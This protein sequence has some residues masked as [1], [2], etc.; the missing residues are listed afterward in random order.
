MADASPLQAPTLRS[1]AL[2]SLEDA[3]RRLENGG[4]DGLAVDL[5]S[6]RVARADSPRGNEGLLQRLRG[7]RMLMALSSSGGDLARMNALPTEVQVAPAV[8]EIL[9]AAM[10]KA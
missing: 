2:S 7:H 9:D 6:G 10:R 5:G 3:I 1:E 8:R 4:G